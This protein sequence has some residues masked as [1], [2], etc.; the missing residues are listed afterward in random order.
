M[1]SELKNTIWERV[2]EVADKSPCQKRKVGCIIVNATGELVSLGYNYNTKFGLEH[3][4]D[5]DDFTYDTVIHA[6][7]MACQQVPDHMKG[8]ELY[9]YVSHE[10]CKACN[11]ILNTICKEI[12]WKD[13]SPKWPNRNSVEETMEEMKD[14]S[15]GEQMEHVGVEPADN[16][17]L[18]NHQADVEGVPSIK[19][20][21]ASSSIEQWRGYCKNTAMKYLYRLDNKDTPDVNAKKAKF[22][23]DKLV[24]SYE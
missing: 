13:L 5:D 20:F 24:E 21:Q 3:C 14:M 18:P 9:A 4:E 23:I 19:F 2:L 1:N 6:E 12:F 10:P 8:E 16:P 15:Y 7:D 17:I 22:F 11:Q